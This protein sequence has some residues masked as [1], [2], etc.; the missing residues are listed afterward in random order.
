LTSSQQRA[1]GNTTAVARLTLGA[2]PTFA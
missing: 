2:Q 1:I